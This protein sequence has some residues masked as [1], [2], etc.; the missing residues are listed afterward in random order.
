VGVWQLSEIRATTISDAAGTGPA[1]LTGQV[2]MRAVLNYNHAATTIRESLNIS[3]V[4]DDGTGRCS[5]SFSNNF[6]D[7][8]YTLVFGGGNDTG[9]NQAGIY[10]AGGTTAKTSSGLGIAIT[11]FAGTN[12]DRDNVCMHN[13]GDLA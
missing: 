10:L 5:P 9:T 8:D 11:S 13:Y 6:S 1:T 4:S 7:S 12:N 3:S 2:A